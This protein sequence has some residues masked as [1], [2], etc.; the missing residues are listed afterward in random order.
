[1]RKVQHFVLKGKEIFVGLEDSKKSWKLCVRNSKMI[2]NETSM[3]AK[4]ETLRQYFKNKFPSCKIHVIYEAGFK[5]FNLY[6]YLV[7]DGCNCVVTPPHTV[8]E[9][10]CSRL[11]NDRIDCRRLAMVLEN[12]DYKE[13]FVHSRK[14]REDRQV[15]RLYGQVQKD[16]VRICN[17]IRRS[18]EFHG[19]DENLPPGKWS[20]RRY[21]MVECM[22]DELDITGSLRF[23]LETQ[24]EDLHYLRSRKKKV[25]QQLQLL[26]Q[27]EHYQQAVD[28]LQSAPGIGL[29]TAIRLALE[30]GDVSR[31]RRK[32]EFASFT[33]LI[34]SDYSS[35]DNDHKGHITKQGNRNVRSWLIESSWIAIRKDPALLE[36]YQIVAHNS[37]S[38]K[39]AI[40]AV[41]RK[42]SIRLRALLLRKEKYV[43]GT[44]N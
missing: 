26:A 16:I 20:Q 14:F 1:M 32:E 3:P 30:W 17:R 38:K 21:R 19:I 27:H 40:V 2:V 12:N 29:L 8:T 24:F 22:L 34:P 44:M 35:G 18:L 10:K 4:Y 6:D 31:F 9:E 11:K 36:K 25:L 7:A 42:F 33:G 43:I 28:V 5:G 41:A 15:S 39:K 23:S 13:C 37:G